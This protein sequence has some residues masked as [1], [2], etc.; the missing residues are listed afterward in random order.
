MGRYDDFW[1]DIKIAAGEWADANKQT[2]RSGRVARPVTTD[3]VSEGLTQFGEQECARKREARR[4]RADEKAANG[5]AAHAQGA[6][7]TSHG[8]RT[9]TDGCHY[10]QAAEPSA[11][12][13]TS[14]GAA[15]LSTRR[16]ATPSTRH[17]TRVAGFGDKQASASDVEQ[18]AGSNGDQASASQTRQTHGETM[19][20]TG[21][22][23][24]PIEVE[25]EDQ[26]IWDIEHELRE[27]QLKMKLKAMREKAKNQA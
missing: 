19:Q 6:R 21:K 3:F 7:L 24:A 20:Q 14:T 2:L 25:D 27:I 8:R 23:T 18:A 11:T 13:M 12:D 26:T 10:A 4:R 5:H 22:R 16:E 9:P 15:A 17:A 1:R